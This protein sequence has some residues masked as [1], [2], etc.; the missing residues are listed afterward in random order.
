MQGSHLC[1]SPL[2]PGR[3]SRAG[4]PKKSDWSLDS[5]AK[6][7]KDKEVEDENKGMKSKCVLAPVTQGVSQPPRRETA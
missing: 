5:E 4:S 3:K 6:A 7:G 1:V 2:P